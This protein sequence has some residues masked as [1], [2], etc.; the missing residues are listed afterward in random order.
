MLYT[1]SLSENKTLELQLEW[2]VPTFLF[3]IYNIQKLFDESN[4]IFWNLS[5]FNDLFDF[6][7]SWTRKTDHA[8]FNLCITILGLFF[9]FS[10]NDNR[11]WDEENNDYCKY[12]EPIPWT[13]EEK[14]I[15]KDGLTKIK[16]DQKLRKEKTPLTEY[17]DIKG[18]Y[19]QSDRLYCYHEKRTDKIQNIS[20]NLFSKFNIYIQLLKNKLKYII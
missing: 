4:I 11:H 3:S 2:N 17:T 15:I 16:E 10:I 6:F 18:K 13:E 8:G 5:I 7:I 1:K 20:F 12:S 9:A 14:Q 19:L